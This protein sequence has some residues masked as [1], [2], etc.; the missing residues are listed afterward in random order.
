M[1]LPFVQ[2]SSEIS[3]SQLAD[4]FVWDMR[5]HLLVA[6]F[7]VHAAK[8]H[9]WCATLQW[10]QVIVWRQGESM[11]SGSTPVRANLPWLPR[12]HR[13]GSRLAGRRQQQHRMRRLPRPPASPQRRR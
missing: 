6:S 5:G 3:F 9:N 13:P 7:Q 11:G 1:G 12:R 10:A 8:G 2:N 4:H